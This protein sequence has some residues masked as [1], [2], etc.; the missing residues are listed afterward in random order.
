MKY[1]KF[2]Q[3]IFNFITDGTG[4][5]V[6]NAVAGSGKTTTIVKALEYIPRSKS[7]IFLAFN[8]SIV[9]EL[10]TRVPSGVHVYTLHGFGYGSVGFHLH[11]KKLNVNNRKAMEYLKEASKQWHD[12][13]QEVVGEYVVRVRKLVDLGRSTLAKTVDE[14]EQL[15]YRHAIEITNGECGR[16]LDAIK[17][18]TA[19]TSQID[20]TDMI[21]MP[22]VMP[23][24]LRQY[25]YVFVDE[26][27]DL[28]AAQQAMLR[29][30]VKPGV[31]RFIAVGD[32]SQAI[33]GFA[34]ADV[35]SFNNLRD[36][37]NTSQLPLS[38]SY[39]CGKKIVEAAKTIVPQIQA[40]EG[41]QD[42]EVIE[43]S[44]LDIKD[45]EMVLCRNTAPITKLCLEMIGQGKKAY[46]KGGDIG[47][48]LINIVNR[49]QLND[50]NHLSE[51]LKKNELDKIVRRLTRKGDTYVD[52]IESQPYQTM[53]DKIQA[54]EIIA[55][56][57][58]KVHEVIAKIEVIFSD[59][60]DGICLST[61]H[62]SKGL[63]ADRV[64][65][66]CANLLPSPYAKQ[67]WQKV[68]ESNLE[69]VMITR[70]KKTLSYIS[71]WK[72]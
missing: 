14:L 45:G 58:E 24:R 22:A 15:A 66:L 4:N 17:V 3:A 46:V 71:D 64:H 35:E 28:N 18:L 9:A 55:S 11:T 7:T 31:G 52:A 10:K 2:Q 60:K 49:Q 41:S 38:V 32:P 19:D 42:G 34:G 50:L 63:E 62:K 33:Y 53:Y 59:E 13:D 29:K 27:Q 43:G 51:V 69:Y 39:R 44:V 48:N 12:V 57:C 68:Q 65:V 30:I 25:D 16:A 1:S 23:M 56:G 5:A 6:V 70:A 61:I 36:T 26:C 72:F 54:I 21:Y 20:F 47:K 67:Q 37:P 8:K 40:F